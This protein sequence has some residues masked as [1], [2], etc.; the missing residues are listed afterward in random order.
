MAI[1]S[2][3]GV[4]RLNGW[5]P[6]LYHP[7]FM[8]VFKDKLFMNYLCNRDYEGEISKQGSKVWLR[9]LPE[10]KTFKYKKGMT[11]PHVEVETEL[12]SFEI[13]RARAWAFKMLTID[14]LLTDMKNADSDI[15]KVFDKQL[16]EDIEV[17]FLAD[18]YAKCHIENQ[19]E[20]A[21]HRSAIYDLGSVTNPLGIFKDSQTTAHKSSAID[22]IA[23]AAAALEEQPGGMGDDPWVV[24]PVWMALRIQTG[25]LKTTSLSGDPT[26]LL[27]KGVTHCGQLAGLNVFTSN[28][29]NSVKQTVGGVA[30]TRCFN[31]IFGDKKGITYA[32]QI[33]KSEVKGIENDFGEK[34]QA[35]HTYDWKAAKPSRFGALYVYAG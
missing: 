22:A 25:E 32:D 31:V 24:I 26:S 16:A 14:K 15:Q 20:G 4:N 9:E 12:D 27:R 10:G 34:F 35:L 33:V 11:L 3:G 8:E 29:L 23:T 7:V 1:Q 18:V 6:E 5:V 19:G 13:N 2:A 28:L 21:G 30:N 17:E